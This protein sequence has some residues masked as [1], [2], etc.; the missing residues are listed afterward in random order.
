MERLRREH[1]EAYIAD[2][3]A[4]WKPSTASN[5]FRGLQQFFKYLVDEGEPEAS[6]MAKMAP[7]Q[8][9]EQPVAVLAEDDLKK[10]LADCA[11]PAFEDRRDQALIR[12]CSTPACAGVSC[13]ACGSRT[14]TLTSRWPSCWA[15]AGGAACPFGRKTARALDR[16]LRARARQPHAEMPW[17]WVQ[18]RGRLN[19]SAW[20]PC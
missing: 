3:L 13:S 15:R 9:P 6:P 1:V 19:E 20:P 17:L 16:Y 10:L 5:R 8:V 11:G 14:S 4:C 7:P 18:R 12:L 2:V